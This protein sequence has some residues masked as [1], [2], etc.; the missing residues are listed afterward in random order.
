MIANLGNGIACVLLTVLYNGW[1]V[2]TADKRLE[3]WPLFFQ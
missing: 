1:P 3:S 2:D